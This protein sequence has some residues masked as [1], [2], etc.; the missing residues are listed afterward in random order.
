MFLKEHEISHLS[1]WYIFRIFLSWISVTTQQTMFHKHDQNRSQWR[2]RL[3]GTPLQIMEKARI[4]HVCLLSDSFCKETAKQCSPASLRSLETWQIFILSKPCWKSFK[5]KL[6]P[7]LIT[8]GNCLLF[9][10][11]PENKVLLPEKFY[12]FPIREMWNIYFKSF[13]KHSQP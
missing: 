1:L 7:L 13:S 2:D 12:G 5:K 8:L 4:T 11:K 3:L 10:W 9:P 6:L